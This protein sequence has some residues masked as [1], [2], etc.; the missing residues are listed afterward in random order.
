MG[1]G[2]VRFINAS[3]NYLTFQILGNRADGQIP[4]DF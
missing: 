4:G 2:T 1:D 3:V